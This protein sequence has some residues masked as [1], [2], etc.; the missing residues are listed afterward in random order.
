MRGPKW[1]L[2][3]DPAGE[4]GTA[5]WGDGVGNGEGLWCGILTCGG[6]GTREDKNDEFSGKG[7]CLGGF[8][9]AVPGVGWGFQLAKT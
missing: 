3:R 8:F 9:C 5:W 6:I 2:V 4:G 1:E 7:I